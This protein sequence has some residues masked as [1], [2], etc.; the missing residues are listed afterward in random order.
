VFFVKHSNDSHLVFTSTAFPAY[1]G[2]DKDINPGI[3]GKR[4]AEFLTNGL[5]KKGFKVLTIGAED[6]GWMIEIENQAFPLWIGCA[7]CDGT[8]NEFQCFIEPSKP[9]VRKWFSKIETGPTVEKLAAALEAVLVQSGKVSKLRWLSD[10]E[11]RR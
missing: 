4:L 5:R 9:F 11:A 3:F 1:P 6:W 2:E 7:N 10:D 8:E